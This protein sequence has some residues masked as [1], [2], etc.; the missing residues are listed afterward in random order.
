MRRH[1]VDDS[2][3]SL[4]APGEQVEEHAEG[5]EEDH[6]DGGGHHH[7]DRGRGGAVPTGAGH[8]ESMRSEESDQ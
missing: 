7:Q 4:L 3:G 1:A 6:S 2:A 5:C 8:P